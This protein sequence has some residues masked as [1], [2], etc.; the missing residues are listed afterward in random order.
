MNVKELEAAARALPDD[1]GRRVEC[2][3]L[4]SD[5]RTAELRI[6]HLLT[7]AEWALMPTPSATRGYIGRVI[8]G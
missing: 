8:R 2:L 4:L 3:S 6:A 7:R 1:D 5:V